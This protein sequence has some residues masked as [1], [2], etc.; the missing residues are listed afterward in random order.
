MSQS[1]VFSV[2]TPVQIVCFTF[3][4]TPFDLKEFHILHQ[5]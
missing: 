4:F 5:D 3:L 2:Q 1:F